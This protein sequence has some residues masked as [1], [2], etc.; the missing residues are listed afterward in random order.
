MEQWSN[1]TFTTHLQ[2]KHRESRVRQAIFPFG[3][4]H[5][6]GLRYG[7]AVKALS[8]LKTLLILEYL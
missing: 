6:S 5:T 3:E 1:I 2:R 7:C 4:T 8:Y